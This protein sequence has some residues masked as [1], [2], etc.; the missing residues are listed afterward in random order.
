LAVA[1]FAVAVGADDLEG[2]VGIHAH[3]RT[4]SNMSVMG[5]CQDWSSILLRS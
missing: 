5:N 2:E 3:T 4:V 1:D